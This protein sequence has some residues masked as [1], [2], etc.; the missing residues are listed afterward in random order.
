MIYNGNSM[1]V[2]SEKFRDYVLAEGPGVLAGYNSH[3]LPILK[4]A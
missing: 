3:D 4:K 2:A 1:S